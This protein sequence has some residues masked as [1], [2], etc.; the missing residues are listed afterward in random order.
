M[1]REASPS[2]AI[3][4]ADCS[5]AC[6]IR[7]ISSDARPT[8]AA[9]SSDSSCER[10]AFAAAWVACPAIC[11]MFAVMCSIDC[12]TVSAAVFCAADPS[13]T[14]LAVPESCLDECATWSELK[15]TLPMMLWK[16]AISSL[17]AFAAG[18]TS[19][20]ITVARCD[21][22]PSRFICSMVARRPWS[23]LLMRMPSSHQ[24]APMPA[25]PATA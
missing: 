3:A 17:N 25:A 15:Y 22:S 21:R 19:G 1:E 9:P 7:L 13:L 8:I 24:I 20:P 23:G 18:P 4:P 14:L 5:T 16:V 12:V 2:L 10:L 11:S 6:A